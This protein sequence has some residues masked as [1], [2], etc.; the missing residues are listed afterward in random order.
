M[1]YMEPRLE[2]LLRELAPQVE[3]PAAGL[4]LLATLD[5]DSRVA[6][7]HR[8]AAARTH[9]FE[10]AGELEAAVHH[11]RVAADRTTST[12]ERN[13]LMIRAAKLAGI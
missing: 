3:G 9:L 2:Q 5:T 10:K 13:Y 6:A 1:K 7:H 12:P 8:L 4:A 11:Y